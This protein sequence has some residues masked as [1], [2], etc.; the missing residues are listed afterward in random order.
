MA[1]T[2]VRSGATFALFCSN[3]LLRDCRVTYFVYTVF[4]MALTLIHGTL[5]VTSS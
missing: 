3:F 2:K 1:S 5:S 4:L